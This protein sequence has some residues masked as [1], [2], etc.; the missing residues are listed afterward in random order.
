MRR[1]RQE[2]STETAQDYVEAIA[3]LT[4]STGEARAVELA[5]RLGVSHVTVVRTVARLQRDGYVSARP[6]RAIFL[7]DKGS[8]LAEE[9]RRG[10]SIV[11]RFLRSL[12]VPEQV[13]QS[14]AEGIE[15]HV[16]PETLAAFERYASRSLEDAL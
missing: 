16:S 9:S 8:R 2:H 3:E 12:G 7:T 13:A 6:Y 14:D 1:T 11:L 5:R 15:H 4:A 10:H